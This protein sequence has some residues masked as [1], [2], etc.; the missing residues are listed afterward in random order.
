[1][2]APRRFFFYGTLLAGMDN[3]VAR[4]AHRVLR[5]EGAARVPGALFA[6]PD[7]AGWYPALVAG[8]GWVQGQIWSVLAGFAG[9]DLAALD[10]YEEC[11]AADRAGSL[12]WRSG[13]CAVRGDGGR[14]AVQ[15]YR[16]D[17]PL[18]RGARPI[19][20]GDFAA[21]LAAQRQAAYRPC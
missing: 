3:A 6:I 1:M 14:Q 5:C 21:W 12:Y 20:G 10:A 9:A 4:V 11:R 19:A 2:N 18:P 13:A 15:L 8:E 17:R 16:Y 7:R